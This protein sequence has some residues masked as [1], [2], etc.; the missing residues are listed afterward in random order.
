MSHGTLCCGYVSILFLDDF[1][2]K[3]SH[4]YSVVTRSVISD[5]TVVEL[6]KDGGH[7]FVKLKELLVCSSTRVFSA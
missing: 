1:I 5:R 2:L 6:K 4:D 7:F 3:N